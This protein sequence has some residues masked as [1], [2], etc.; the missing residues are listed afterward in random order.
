MLRFAVRPEAPDHDVIVRAARVLR[1]GGLVAFPTETVYGLG[2]C[3]LRGACV[4]RIFEAK[5]RPSWNPLIVHVTGPEMARNLVV[6]AWPQAAEV[7]TRKFWPGPLSLVLPRRENVPVEVCAGLPSVGVRAPRHAVALALIEALG[8]PVAAPSANRFQEISPTTADHVEKSLGAAVDM[9]LDGGAAS[10]GVE[11]TVVD[12]TGPGPK[13]LRAGGISLEQ[14]RAALPSSSWSV[15][16][17]VSDGAARASPGQVQKHYAPR[18][19]TRIVPFGAASEWDRV[20]GTSP[21]P[22]GTLSFSL[23]ALGDVKEVLPVDAERAQA[24]LFA[25]MHALEDAQCAS[26]VMELPPDGMAWDAVRDRMT[27]AAA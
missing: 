23:P 24:R 10:V 9:I 17:S 1:D 18:A 11:S 5:G 12:L 25:A 20:V 4:R 3:A 21:R 8:E 16:E 27:R 2:A 7:L 26:I 6:S 15:A 19:A 22:L 14:L 13:L